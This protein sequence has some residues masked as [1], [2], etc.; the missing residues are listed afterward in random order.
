MLN[1]LPTC[2]VS[3]KLMMQVAVRAG[4][5]VPTLESLLSKGEQD[6]YDFAFVGETLISNH[7]DCCLAIRF[8]CSQM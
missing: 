4:K 3:C 5:G 1:V 6:S 8:G 2:A 7:W